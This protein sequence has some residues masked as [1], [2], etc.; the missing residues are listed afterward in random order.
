MQ[1]I[2]Y[3]DIFIYNNRFGYEVSFKGNEKSVFSSVSASVNL[4]NN[5]IIQ[6]QLKPN[7][8]KLCLLAQSQRNMQLRCDLAIRDLMGVNGTANLEVEVTTHAT[9]V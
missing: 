9:I 5:S 4:F 2:S 3:I 6:P 1:R 7:G 8:V